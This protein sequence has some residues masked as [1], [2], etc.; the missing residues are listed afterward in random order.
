M[1]NWQNILF[2]R[3][4]RIFWPKKWGCPDVL[5]IPRN[6]TP[7][8]TLQHYAIDIENKASRFNPNVIYARNLAL[9]HV[10]CIRGV[11]PGEVWEV[12]TSPLFWPKY[13]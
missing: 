12:R 4:L 3:I 7:E 8:N 13:V 5:D 6:Y 1:I 11:I 2:F 9:I 10:N